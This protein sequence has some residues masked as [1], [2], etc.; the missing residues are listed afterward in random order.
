MTQVPSAKRPPPQM[1]SSRASTPVTARQPLQSRL[2]TFPEA[3]LHPGSQAVCPASHW[4]PQPP[5]GCCLPWG[6]LSLGSHTGGRFRRCHLVSTRSARRSA[7][8]PA[9]KGQESALGLLPP[10]GAPVFLSPS[11][12]PPILKAST[13]SSPLLARSLPPQPPASHKTRGKVL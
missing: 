9:G 7:A 12:L 13:E 5:Q 8:G 1:P 4:A 2:P 6:F 10:G 3:I 11:L